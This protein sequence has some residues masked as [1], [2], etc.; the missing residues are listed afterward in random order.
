MNKAR[1]GFTLIELLIVIAVLGALTAMMTLSSAG[2]VGSANA[3]KIT[4]GLQVLRTAAQAFCAEYAN[5]EN[6][7][8]TSF[9]NMSADY[10][11]A[12]YIDSVRKNFVL[13]VSGDQKGIDANWY[14]GY[15]QLENTETKNKLA[16]HAEEN[17][18]FGSA[19]TSPATD[20]SIAVYTNQSYVFLRI[21]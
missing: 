20:G 6:V 7:T 15:G 1:R 2:A 18:L 19:N 16:A 8:I 13:V 5:A 17:Q 3:A 9:D 21:H 12:T 4:H 10:I 11:D 14:A